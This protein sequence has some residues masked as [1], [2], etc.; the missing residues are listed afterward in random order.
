MADFKHGSD[1]AQDIDVLVTARHHDEKAGKLPLRADELD[2]LIYALITLQGWTPFLGA[3]NYN[4]MRMNGGFSS[5]PQFRLAIERGSGAEFRRDV[6]VL[7]AG[8]GRIADEF[9]L[10]HD[11]AD[12]PEH[13]LLWLP[14]WDDA[15]L[16]LSCVHPLALE[17]SRRVRLIERDGTLQLLRAGSKSMRV[18]ASI[19][20]GDVLDPWTPILVIDGRKA[21]SAQPDT[22]GYR[23]LP[24]LLFSRNKCELPLL[25]LPAEHERSR[26]AKLIVQALAGGKGKTNGLLQR[27]ISMPASVTRRLGHEVVDLARRSQLFVDRASEM[28]GKVFRSALIQFVD[29]SDDVD[30]K[31]KDFDRATRS[32]VDDY[33][34]DVDEAFFPELFRSIDAGH[35]DQLAQVHWVQ[36]LYTLAQ[37]RLPV[38]TEALPTRSPSRPFALARAERVL[39]GGARKHFGTWLAQARAE[40]QN[41]DT[42]ESTR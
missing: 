16:P 18:D 29:G 34:R 31:N 38:A 23:E 26:S 1:A 11:G 9:R 32:A 19:W 33:E 37:R 8:L 36:W 15:P 17:V 22:L 2:T 10:R 7:T 41:E 35:D 42:T 30:W 6:E 25:A 27:E 24:G 20:N 28:S 4:S 5:R 14:L 12:K 3:G 13:R 40:A 21:L 39:H